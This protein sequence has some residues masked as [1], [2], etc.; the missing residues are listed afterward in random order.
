MSDGTPT[1]P[2]SRAPRSRPTPQQST[3]SATNPNNECSRSLGVLS[4]PRGNAAEAT[5]GQ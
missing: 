2:P 5:A 3:V 1:H 4:N